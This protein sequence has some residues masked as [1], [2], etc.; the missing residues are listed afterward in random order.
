MITV[1]Y[2]H[3]LDIPWLEGLD[4]GIEGWVNLLRVHHVETYESC[5]GGEGHSYPEPTIAFR[6]NRSAGFHALHVALTHDLPVSEIRR[7]WEIYDG[8]DPHGPIWQIVFRRKADAAETELMRGV[9]AFELG[10]T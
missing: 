8:G 10:D 4:P 5:E 1:G 2:A 6:G 9:I 7:V 3:V